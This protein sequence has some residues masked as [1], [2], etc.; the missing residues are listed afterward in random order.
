[1]M[2]QSLGGKRVFKTRRQGEDNSVDKQLRVSD[3]AVGLE[4]D[5]DFD[6]ALNINVDGDYFGGNS[7]F[8]SN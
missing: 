4:Q 2:D 8:T 3:A 5:G 6:R 7:L 1:M